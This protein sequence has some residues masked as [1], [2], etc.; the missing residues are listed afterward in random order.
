MCTQEETQVTT[1][2]I[3]AVSPSYL[4]A[5]EIGISD[6]K[7]QFHNSTYRPDSKLTKKNKAIEITKAAQILTTLKNML[8]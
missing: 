7:T 2:N 3:A 8:P 5:K 1:K 4:K 6:N